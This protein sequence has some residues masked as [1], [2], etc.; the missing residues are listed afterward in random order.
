V[1]ADP[2]RS[3]GQVITDSPAPVAEPDAGDSGSAASGTA[4]GT[5]TVAVEAVGS[6]H[7]PEAGLEGQQILTITAAADYVGVSDETMRR[8]VKDG[9]V[10]AE[11]VDRGRFKFQKDELDRLRAA[12]EKKRERLKNAE[13]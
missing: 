7:R 10:V 11:P 9:N 8:W 4:A 5:Q 6:G 3:L 2:E 1:E 13:E 12:Q